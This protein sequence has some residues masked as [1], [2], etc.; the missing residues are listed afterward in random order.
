MLHPGDAGRLDATEIPRLQTIV[1]PLDGSS[2]SERALPLAGLIAQAASASVHLVRAVWSVQGP[3]PNSTADQK[4]DEA[5]ARL[6]LIRRGEEL[7]TKGM[8]FD[9]EVRAAPPAAGILHAVDRRDASL[10]VMSTHGRSGVGRW[11]YGSVAEEVL[12]HCRVPVV[13]VRSADLDLSQGWGRKRLLLPL[14]GSPSADAVVP[15]TAALARAL[16]ATVV[17]LHAKRQRDTDGHERG[18]GSGVWSADGEPMAH[19]E[20]VAEALRSHGL[21]VVVAFRAANSPA[22]AIVVEATQSGAGIVTMATHGRSGLSRLIMGSV[23]AEVLRRSTIPVLVARP[24]SH[25][26]FGR[27]TANPEP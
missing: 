15:T 13:M 25:P 11:V 26:R 5:S 1:V 8:P 19:V 4:A 18:D 9:V 21:R 20:R 3:E 10:V 27:R 14:D 24:G 23:T 22:T 7:A 12:G 17:L 16:D 2:L 6:Y